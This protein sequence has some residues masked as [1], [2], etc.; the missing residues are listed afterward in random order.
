MN[1]SRCTGQV[2]GTP[3]ARRLGSSGA[4][5]R[6]TRATVL[7]RGS[8]SAFSDAPAIEGTSALPLS[9]KSP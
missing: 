7:P 4:A 5:P 1:A 6:V 9:T 8:A 2:G 3:S